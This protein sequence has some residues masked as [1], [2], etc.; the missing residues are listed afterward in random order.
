M[1]AHRARVEHLRP[2]GWWRRDMLLKILEAMYP[3]WMAAREFP[4]I[5]AHLRNDP[6]ETTG[7]RRCCTVRTLTRFH[8]YGYVDRHGE[9]VKLK[10]RKPGTDWKGGWLAG[11][12][13]RYRLRY[14]PGEQSYL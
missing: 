6:R 5:V 9:P 1:L 7:W 8:T 11:E 13:Y 14:P 10:G 2:G 12:G 3:N 4:P